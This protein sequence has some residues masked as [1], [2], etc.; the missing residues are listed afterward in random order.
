MTAPILSV[1]DL[2]TRFYTERGVVLA[3]DGVSF[4]VHEREAIG[5]VGE[6]GSGKSVTALSTLRLVPQPG[7]IVGGEIRLRDRDLASLPDHEIRDVRRRDIAMIFQD[8]A[9]FLNPIM[10]IGDQIGEGLDGQEK[11]KEAIRAEVIEALR[12]VRIPDPERIADSYPFQLSGG[13][14]QRAVI[15][16]AVIRRPAIIFADEPTT[17]LD[18]TV[19]FQILRLLATLQATLNTALVLISHDLAVVAS[20]CSRVYVM[21]AGH[22]VES[23]RANDI[24]DAPAHPYTQ[25]LLASILD[26][27]EPPKKLTAMGGSLPDMTNPPSGCR[28][29]P[30]C[31]FAMAICQTDAPPFFEIGPGHTARCWL[32][33]NRARTAQ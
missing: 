1:K 17:A 25:G 7:R 30:R 14:Q 27:L 32:H 29:H 5:I 10:T 21:Y 13:M 31:P 8:P 15:A 24:Y 9:S 22:V 6:S 26:P 20:V 16:S 18:A 19:Q 4:E 23:G 12:L 3:V 33:S 11:S 28:F 2:D